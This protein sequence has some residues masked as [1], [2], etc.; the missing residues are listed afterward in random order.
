MFKDILIKRMDKRGIFCL[1]FWVFGFYRYNMESTMISYIC[2]GSYILNCFFLQLHGC[3]FH[4]MKAWQRYMKSHKLAA[5]QYKSGAFHH[6]VKLVHAL[7]FVPPDKVSCI[8]IWR[9][10]YVLFF[11]VVFFSEHYFQMV[12]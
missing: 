3:Y 10:C 1:V 11:A 12:Q 6:I 9:P 8:G 7:P 4:L 2:E 5:L